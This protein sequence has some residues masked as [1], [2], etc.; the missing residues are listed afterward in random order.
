MFCRMSNA[1]HRSM[2]Q[3]F[4]YYQCERRPHCS[5]VDK[6]SVQSLDT[7]RTL[8]QTVVSLRSALEEARR[9]IDSLKKQIIISN[10]IEE[11]KI[12]RTQDNENKETTTAAANIDIE[13]DSV[14]KNKRKSNDQHKLLKECDR[15]IEKIKN[16]KINLTEIQESADNSSINYS[17]HCLP[18]KISTNLK[19]AMASKI[20]VKIKLSSNIKIDSG[21]AESSSSEMTSGKLYIRF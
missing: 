19:S 18:T 7:V 15:K 6:N 21:G 5:P 10:D 20:D 16:S 17:I 4:D 1:C 3:V 13:S 12:Y 9:E 2:D 14:K 8:H 11:G